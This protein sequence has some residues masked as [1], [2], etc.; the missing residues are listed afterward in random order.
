M[1]AKPVFRHYADNTS[2]QA[3][4]RTPPRLSEIPLTWRRDLALGGP[5]PVRRP[6]RTIFM[7][8]E[9]PSLPAAPERCS[10]PHVTGPRMYDELRTSRRSLRWAPPNGR[11]CLTQ[12]G[13]EGLHV[14][15]TGVEVGPGHQHHQMTPDHAEDARGSFPGC[16]PDIVRSAPL[17]SD[18]RHV[19]PVVSTGL[20]PCEPGVDLLLA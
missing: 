13:L 3:Q 2:S 4:K 6:L 16:L 14:P 5:A 7:A 11:D 20:S 15:V 8:G 19:L 17:R 9:S 10:V 18:R 12:T 1:N